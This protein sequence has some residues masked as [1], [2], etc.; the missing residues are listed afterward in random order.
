MK[1]L[2]VTATFPPRTFGGVT[3]VSYNLA[4]QLAA[5]GHEVTVLTT[6]LGDRNARIPDGSLPTDCPGL[7]VRYFTNIN[8]RLAARKVFLPWGIVSAIRDTVSEFDIVHL[9]EFRSLPSVA[10]HRYATKKRVPYVL[11]AHGGVMTFFEKG[12][13]KKAYDKIW[14][15]R[16]IHDAASLIATTAAEAKQY[17]RMGGEAGRIAILPNGIEDSEFEQRPPRGEFRRRIGI[18]DGHRIILYLGRINRVKGVDILVRAFAELC[19]HESDL[20]LLIAGPDDGYLPSVKKLANACGCEG[21][22]RY[23]GAL[24]GGPKLSAY[25]DSDVFVLPSRYD[26]FGIVAFEALMAGLPIVVTDNCGTADLIQGRRMGYVARADDSGNLALFIA[27][28][29]SSPVE[30]REQVQRGQQF[31][32]ENLKW[33]ILVRRL[34]AIYESSILG[35]NENHGYS[36][37]YRRC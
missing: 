13:L 15:V 32:M 33:S 11:Q 9:H 29:L 20:E 14:G 8:N 31:V 2:F 34:E 36:H 12:L 37:R 21:R 19:K 24:T 10:V 6:D 7:S 1:I 18:P 22:V 25:V 28:S 16:L 4:K 17:G 27:K 26:I 5:R 3:T 35:A 23:A 30:T